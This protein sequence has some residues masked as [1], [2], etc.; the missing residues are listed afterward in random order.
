ME[1]VLVIVLTYLVLPQSSFLQWQGLDNEYLLVFGYPVIA[2]S[3]FI[4][5]IRFAI[6]GA[7]GMRGSDTRGIINYP[8]TFYP[9]IN[10]LQ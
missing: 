6:A 5:T 10:W 2:Q 9:I 4:W 8:F 7:D 3:G 1:C